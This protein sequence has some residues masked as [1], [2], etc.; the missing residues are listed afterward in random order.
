MNMK[1]AGSTSG[2]L[3]FVT[4]WIQAPV[5][6]STAKEKPVMVQSMPALQS[7]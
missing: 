3:D 4:T 1:P 5:D 6:N 7:Y 2:G